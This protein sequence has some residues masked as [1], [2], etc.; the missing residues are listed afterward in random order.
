MYYI[1]FNLDRANQSIVILPV[2][3]IQKTEQPLPDTPGVDAYM[4]KLDHPLKAVLEALRQ[5]ILSVDP[6]L[7]EHIKW[8]A[9]SFLYTGEMKPFDPKAYKRYVIVSNLFKK[10]CIRLVFLR[11]DKI[12]DTS[13]FLTG[14]YADGRRLAFFHNM[15]EVKEKEEA[16]RNAIKVWLSVLDK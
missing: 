4:Q 8:N 13:G 5:I 10:D 11:G 2:M 16:L 15:D 12:N 6:A 3:K 9:P 7:G 1:F 14:T